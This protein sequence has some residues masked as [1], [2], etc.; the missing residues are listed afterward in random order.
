MLDKAAHPHSLS[1]SFQ[2]KITGHNALLKEAPALYL[3]LFYFVY[4]N[5]NNNNNNII[6]L[7][8]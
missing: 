4:N 3:L 5:N 6:C 8:L 1:T 2:K 7:L